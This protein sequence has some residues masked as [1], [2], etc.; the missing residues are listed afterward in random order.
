MTRSFHA[1]L[2]A[3][4][5]ISAA[6][7]AGDAKPLTFEDAVRPILKAHCFECHGEGEKLKGGLDV[8]L[9]RLLVHGGKAG[10]ALHVGKAKDSILIERLQSGE[11]PPGKKKLTRDEIATI[12]R[13]ID[14]GALTARPEPAKLAAGFQLSEDEKSYWFFQPI[15]SPAIPKVKNQDRVRTPID[16]F[17]LAKLEAK[18]LTFAADAERATLIRRATFDLVGLPPSPR[19][20]DDFVHDKAG[21]A[22]EKLLDRLLASPHYGERWGRHWLDVAGYA[23]SEGYTG[24]DVVRPT[25]YRYRDYV[26]RAFNADKPFDEFIHEQLAGDELVAS[27]YDK[28]SPAQ[29]DKLIATGFLR[30]A[31]DGTASKEFNLKEASNQTIA[32]TIQIVSTSLM[33]LTMHCAQC[34]NHRYDQIPQIDYFRLRAVFEPGFNTRTWRTPKLREIATVD[35]ATKKQIAAIEAA[36]QKVDQER[37]V[38]AQKYVKAVLDRALALVPD[39]QKAAVQK[40]LKLAPGARS[41]AQTAM[42]A[43][44][45][46]LLV[47]AANVGMYDDAAK[48]ELPEL[49]EKS[50]KLRATKPAGDT[51]RAFTEMPGQVPPTLFFERGDPDQAK[52]EVKPGHLAILARFNLPPLPDRDPKLPTTGRRL[53]LARSLTG[54]EHPLTTRVLVNRFWM[55]HFGKG[56]VASAG[57]FGFLGD[58]PTHPELLDWLAR[59]F[60]TSRERKRPDERPEAWSLKR[61][62]KQVMLSTAYRQASTASA[63]ARAADPDNKLLGRMNVRRLES[64]IVR[65]AMLAVSG[66]LNVKPFGPPVPVMP[67]LAGQIVIGVDTNDGAGRPTGKFIPLNGEEYRRSLYVQVRRSKPLAVLE[68]FDAPIVSPNC[69]RRNVTTVTPQA[70]MLMNSKAVIEQADFFAKRLKQEA[71]TD[72]KLQVKLAWNYA[73]GQEPAAQDVALASTFL[74]EQT[75]FYEQ[76]KNLPTVADPALAALTNFCQA[77]LTANAFLYVD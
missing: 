6:A 11:M 29:L 7:F 42:L 18:G 32:D 9:K 20:V 73:W 45:K 26:I 52:G 38:K 61:F 21:D 74:A 55:H 77:M 51:I 41:V 53:A 4:L 49:L 59:D 14:G 44:Y 35:A 15:Q 64:E 56:I 76:R 72:P 28:L 48:K 47:T 24:E 36:A 75:K 43:K 71:G 13:W 10:P 66:K 40:A 70:L 46:G 5:S 69:E 12:A 33:G 50:A 27:P 62:H 39:D 31:P 8:R 57:D 1:A 34:H 58:R 19:E 60:M 3:S 63:D 37:V 65:D 17:L 23:D 67:D 54:P 16:A 68:A 2:L 30:M 22:Y 25:A